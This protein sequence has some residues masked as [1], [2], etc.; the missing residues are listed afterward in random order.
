MTIE[1][2]KRCHLQTLLIAIVIREFSIWQTLIPTLSILHSTGSQH[3]FKNLIYPFVLTISLRMISKTEAQLGIQGFMHPLPKH[4]SKLS[5]SIQHNLLWHSIEIDY[6]RHIQLYY[7]RSRV[8]CVDKYK[9]SHLCQSIHNH[10][11][12]II[13]RLSFLQTHDKIYDNLFHFHSVTCNGCN[14]PA[15][16]RCSAWTH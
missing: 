12:G 5:P 15:G 3:I 11:N 13:D 14:N 10:P 4:Q 6:P 7:F 1:H 16:C 8:G 2:L 9:V